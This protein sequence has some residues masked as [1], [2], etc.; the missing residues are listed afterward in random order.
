MKKKLGDRLRALSLA[1]Q[2]RYIHLTAFLIILQNCQYS[3]STPLKIALFLKNRTVA[4]AL[5]PKSPGTEW[6]ASAFFISHDGFLITTAHSLNGA[7][8][9]YV[10]LESKSAKVIA[11]DLV[12]DLA[13]LKV[14][15][16]QKE[17]DFID[18][19]KFNEGNY[20]EVVYS[21]GSPFGEI[22]SFFIN[23]ISKPKTF[24]GDPTEPNATYI[25]LER[26]FFPGFSGAP[27][28][29][30]RN[31]FIG[32]ARHQVAVRE[33]KHSGLGYAIHAKNVYQFAREYLNE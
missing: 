12:L 20:A 31:E 10:S 14:E 3:E 25:Q 30:A 18:I 16:L 28:V 8:Q 32:V 24:G 15:D 27:L 19:R 5:E 4:L 33:S 23:S 21:M 22:D 13:L 7:N 9:A 11:K 17:V 29:N 6:A 26:I 1:S 2:F